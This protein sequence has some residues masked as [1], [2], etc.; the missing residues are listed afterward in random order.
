MSDMRGEYPKQP[1]L[2]D[3]MLSPQEVRSELARF[4]EELMSDGN[5]GAAIIAE[6]FESM[7]EPEN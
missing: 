6:A 2:N 1:D 4:R 3:A 5:V 7:E